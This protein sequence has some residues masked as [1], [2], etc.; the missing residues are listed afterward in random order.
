MAGRQQ[1]Q[2]RFLAEFFAAAR[3]EVDR[4]PEIESLASRDA[5][6][7]ND[8]MARRGFPSFFSPFAGQRFGIASVL[9]LL[10]EWAR[11]GYATEIGREDG[12]RFPAVRIASE[13]VRFLR[14]DGH[15]N[16][17]ARLATKSGAIVYMT[18]L[19]DPPAGLALL[20]RAHELS[21][22]GGEVYDFDGLVFP[23]V[24]LD[25]AVGLG[26]LLKLATDDEEG[27]PWEI[28]A[29]LQLNRLRMNEIGARAESA[30]ML[31][32]AAVG[33]GWEPKPEH[34]IDRPFLVWFERD[35]LS[36]PLFAAYVAEEEWRNPGTIA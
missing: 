28:E 10:V 33:V 26:W 22:A 25:Q 31:Q 27:M 2:E 1:E 19:D 18:M 4:I 11:E 3:A 23:M 7:L 36:R 15:G 5:T 17:V 12:R 29:A 30:V 32:P 21:R 13:A 8:F 16:P 6:E 20:E 34:V 9:D 14:A 35:G 24:H